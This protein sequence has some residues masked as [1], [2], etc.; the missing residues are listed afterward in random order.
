VLNNTVTGG[1]I[2]GI[3]MH[4]SGGGALTGTQIIGNHFSANGGQEVV[5]NAP[6]GTG[7]EILGTGN[8]SRTQVLHNAVSNDYYGVF[9]VGDVAT[10][11][12]QLT[13]HG[14]TVPVAP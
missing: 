8:I 7:V 1:Y 11:V 12:A 4:S 5:D 2:A 14:V 3:G 10:H 9:H 13:T 6:V